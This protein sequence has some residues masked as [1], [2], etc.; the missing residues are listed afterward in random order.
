MAEPY[1]G[2]IRQ[3]NPFLLMNDLTDLHRCDGSSLIT[4]WRPPH[5]CWS[6]ASFRRG[7]S[8]WRL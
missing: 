1:A 6:V 4:R 3:L 8:L 2:P 5:Q 7:A